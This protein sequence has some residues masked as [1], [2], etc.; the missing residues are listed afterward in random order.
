MWNRTAWVGALTLLLGCSDPTVPT[1]ELLRL[2]GTVTDAVTQIPIEGAQIIL[3]WPA[4]AFG[5]GT[6]WAETNTEGRYSLDR[7]FGGAPFT[8]HGFG[9]TAQATEYHAEFV[10]P[11]NIRC[12]S[13]VQTFDF[14]LEPESA[15]SESGS[16]ENP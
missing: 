9:M 16:V 8:C 1:I 4:G 7:D 14:E 2:Q 10:Q 13:E 15:V 11:G 5:T 3:Q 6:E 12:V